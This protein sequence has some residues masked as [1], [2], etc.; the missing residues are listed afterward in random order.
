VVRL[1]TLLQRETISVPGQKRRYAV[2]R[3]CDGFRSGG[4]SCSSL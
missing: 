1:Q 2:V 3:F 4:V